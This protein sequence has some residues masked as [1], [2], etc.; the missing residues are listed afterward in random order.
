MGERGKSPE[1]N[2][3]NRYHPNVPTLIYHFIFRHIC[4]IAASG[5]PWVK[6]KT[7]PHTLRAKRDKEADNS[8]SVDGSFKKPRELTL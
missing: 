8:R 3:L 6:F 7:G 4:Q 1:R 2:E 5:V